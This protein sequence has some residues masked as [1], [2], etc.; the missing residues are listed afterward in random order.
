MRHFKNIL[1]LLALLLFFSCRF[2]RRHSNLNNGVQSNPLRQ[3]IHIPIIDSYMKKDNKPAF[4]GGERWDSKIDFFR[5]N[6]ILHYWKIIRPYDSFK[7]FSEEEDAYRIKLN[8]TIGMQLN[9][10]SKIKSD[11]IVTRSGNLFSFAL[12]RPDSEPLTSFMILDEKGI[13]SVVKSWGLY[14]LVLQK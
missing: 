12:A 9:I 4:L 3:K 8:D 13:D 5:K 1:F 6:Q 14:Y 7:A 11:S 2:P 10:H